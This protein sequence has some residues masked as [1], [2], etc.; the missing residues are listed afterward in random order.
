MGCAACHLQGTDP[1]AGRMSW[2]R[3]SIVVL[4]NSGHAM[5]SVWWVGVF[6][7]VGQEEHQQCL[8]H[9]VGAHW[10]VLQQEMQAGGEGPVGQCPLV[11]VK[12]QQMPWFQPGVSSR[13]HLIPHHTQPL[14]K[15]DLKRAARGVGRWMA[16]F[17]SYDPGCPCRPVQGLSQELL[18]M[19]YHWRNVFRKPKFHHLPGHLSLSFTESQNVESQKCR[20]VGSEGPSQPPAP[21]LPRAGCPPAQAAQGPSM[22]WGTSR[23]GPRSS[24]QQCQH[25]TA[26]RVKNFITK[27]EAVDH[28]R[29]SKTTELSISLKGAS[30]CQ[31][32][33][34]ST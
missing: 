29:D 17:W 30:S 26:L 13:A 25:L 24:G 2:N 21:P 7:R 22:A 16:Q 33:R 11:L 15:W 19:R 27:L 9:G 18:A 31:C 23:D 1:A 12:A 8:H 6:Q 10:W 14:L 34:S 20:E 3:M 28:W 4:F 5:S 32:L